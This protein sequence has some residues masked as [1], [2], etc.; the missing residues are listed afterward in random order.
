MKNSNKNLNNLKNVAIK[1]E[2]AKKVKG[3]FIIIED[4][5]V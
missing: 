2:D 1:R 5:D 3:G 4:M